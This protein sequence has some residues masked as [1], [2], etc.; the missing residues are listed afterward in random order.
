MNKM[1]RALLIIRRLCLSNSPQFFIPF[2]IFA[3]VSTK[4]VLTYLLVS[5]F[6]IVLPGSNMLS[7]LNF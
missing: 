3:S 4:I 7:I 1:N 6:F 2:H 5:F